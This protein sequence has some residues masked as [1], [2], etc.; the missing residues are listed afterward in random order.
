MGMEIF[1]GVIL[2]EDGF[3]EGYIRTD[4]GKITEIGDG[5][6]PY[7]VDYGGAVVPSMVNSHTHCADYG[8][9]VTQ[10]MSL[11]DLVA[12][13]NGLKHRY[14][15]ESSDV[16]LSDNMR[17]Y[18]IAS[19]NNGIGT[20]IDFR[21][22]GAAGCELLRKVSPNAT[23]LG[24]SSSG[25]YDADEM[26]AILR[27]ADG[28]GLP[29]IS[30]MAL[31]DVE[32]I[33]DHVR[34]SGKMFSIHVSERVREDIDIVL[35]MDPTFVVHMTEATDSD[36]LK[37]AEVE[38][39]IVVC[40]RSNLYFGKT[41]PLKRMLN[42]GA[43]ISIGTDNAMLCEPDL[44]AEASVFMDVLMA[45]GG[46]PDDIVDPLFLC[47][48]KILYSAN[49]LHLSEGM[50]AEFTVLPYSGRFEIGKMLSD[51]SKIV[52]RGTGAAE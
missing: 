51:K 23:I 52:V 36:I 46:Y 32:D 16:V 33:A 49:K 44:R 13:Q 28:I 34:K 7:R 1:G 17:E 4:D 24:R 18:S 19:S 45:Q 21:E 15:R 38:V 2:T 50:K 43:D 6:C 42:A 5:R 14:L 22:G 40:A 3:V 41:P 8:L 35:S 48:R 30:D 9:K 37:C 39:P 31:E 47:G 27:V 11:E 10:G 25:K 26:D 20:F 12:P 29:S